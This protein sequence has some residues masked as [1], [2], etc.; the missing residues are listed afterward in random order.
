M[1]LITCSSLETLAQA[2][3]STAQHRRLDSMAL[4]EEQAGDNSE[5]RTDRVRGG[6][7]FSPSLN[8]SNYR[9]MMKLQLLFG[10]TFL[11][12][13]ACKAKGGV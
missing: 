4:Q 3:N 5:G 7:L 12:G 10:S 8:W 11:R 13:L 9:W 6:Q 2:P 1:C